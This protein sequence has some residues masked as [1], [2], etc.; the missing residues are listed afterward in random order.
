MFLLRADA[1]HL[2][3]KEDCHKQIY[4]FLAALFHEMAPLVPPQLSVTEVV[5]KY[6]RAV[7]AAK[8]RKK[9][10]QTESFV[11]AAKDFCRQK[12]SLVFFAVR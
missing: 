12:K 9:Q 5:H 10:Q 3:V 11:R 2:F 7:N 8:V 6:R 4:L 1:K